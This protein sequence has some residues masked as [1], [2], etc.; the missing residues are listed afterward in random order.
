MFEL[1]WALNIF[2]FVDDWLNFIVMFM[3]NCDAC[4]LTK[5]KN[6]CV[7]HTI[8]TLKNILNIFIFLEK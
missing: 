3:F 8:N 4:V 7:L 2:F 5:Y 1:S 6:I